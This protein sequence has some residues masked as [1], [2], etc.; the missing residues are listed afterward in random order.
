MARGNK[1][2]MG[3]RCDVRYGSLAAAPFNSGS[4]RLTPEI[5]HGGMPIGIFDQRDTRDFSC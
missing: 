2:K 1:A 3:K 5:G 4:V